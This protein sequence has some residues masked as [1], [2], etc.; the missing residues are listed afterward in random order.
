MGVESPPSFDQSDRGMNEC[1]EHLPSCHATVPGVA[2][3][4]GAVIPRTDTVHRDRDMVR[5]TLY[6]PSPHST[7]SS[8]S[9]PVW[10][11][12]ST[13]PHAT[14]VLSAVGVLRIS[15]WKFHCNHVLETEQRKFCSL[16]GIFMV[17]MA[18]R[19]A[20]LAAEPSARTPARRAVYQH[21][22]VMRRSCTVAPSAPGPE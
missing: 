5:E 4:D 19:A 17:V 3:P 9:L 14:H 21:A 12:I 6:P 20:A 1:V 2:A 8:S 22:E 15:H 11:W 7:H 13:L 16:S 18:H 10:T